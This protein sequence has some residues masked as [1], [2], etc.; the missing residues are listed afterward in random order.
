MKRI[1]FDDPVQWWGPFAV[2]LILSGAAAGGAW[3]YGASA[4]EGFCLGGVFFVVLLLVVAGQGWLYW[5]TE[6]SRLT[7]DGSEVE[8]GLMRWIGR[9]GRVRFAPGEAT[10]WT[11]LSLSS[12][13]DQS[14]ARPNLSFTL[15]GKTY[16]L[17]LKGARIADIDG[18]KAIEPAFFDRL[19]ADHPNLRT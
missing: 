6:I 8:A 3:W 11:V 9:P 7:L 19:V 17:T 16:R 10:H 2:V 1:V 13:A 14:K 18:L 12:D 15:R 5:T 4:G